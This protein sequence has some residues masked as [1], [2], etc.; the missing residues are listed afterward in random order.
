MNEGTQGLL[1]SW[2]AVIAEFERIVAI[3]DSGFSLETIA[4]TRHFLNF[5]RSHCPIPSDICKGYWPTIRVCWNDEPA[6][7][8][9]IFGD[10]FETYRFPSGALDIKYWYP[11]IGA[12]F[13]SEFICE[14]P[15]K[16]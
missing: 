5:A 14:L 9:E 8:V 15:A 1:D 12:P 13:A 4:Q 6:F 3:A 16:A 2:D 10:H 7:E 11:A